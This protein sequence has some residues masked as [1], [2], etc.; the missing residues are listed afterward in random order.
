MIWQSKACLGGSPR[1]PSRASPPPP[2]VGQLGKELAVA[3]LGFRCSEYLSRSPSHHLHHVT[4]SRYITL[5]SSRYITSRYIPS[6]YVTSRPVTRFKVRGTTLHHV[7]SRHVPFPGASF[8]VPA[9]LN[10]LR[11]CHTTC[12]CR[13]SIS[14]LLYLVTLS[15]GHLLSFSS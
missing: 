13:S 9:Q 15:C 1:C 5:L 12:G 11:S 4:S 10:L 8:E 14:D 7:T 2:L 6:H 3:P